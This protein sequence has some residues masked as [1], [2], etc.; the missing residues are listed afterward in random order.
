MNALL[1]RVYSYAGDSTNA[2]ASAEEVINKSG[3]ELSSNNQDDPILF[4]ECICALCTYLHL[5][6][7]VK[8][9]LLDGVYTTHRYILRIK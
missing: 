2:I 8:G 5:P 6:R 7:I 4:S 1:A 3:L 9:L